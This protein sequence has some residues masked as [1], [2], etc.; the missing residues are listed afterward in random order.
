VGFDWRVNRRQQDLLLAA[1]QH[2]NFNHF[3]TL[4]DAVE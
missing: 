3:T 1:I 4:D 2:T